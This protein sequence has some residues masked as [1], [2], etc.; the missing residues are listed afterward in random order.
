[1]A[2]YLALRNSS[3]QDFKFRMG[4]S[5]HWFP[6]K[7]NSVDKTRTCKPCVNTVLPYTKPYQAA[8]LKT[9][10]MLWLIVDHILRYPF[11]EAGSSM[12]TSLLEDDRKIHL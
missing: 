5:K 1:M 3:N 8:I 2:F 11:R 4:W 12:L 10:L 7:S 9:S 6:S